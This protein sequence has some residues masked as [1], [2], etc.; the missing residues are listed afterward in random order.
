MPSV[1]AF[2]EN[3]L[4]EEREEVQQR[5]TETLHREKGALQRIKESEEA[6]Q[7]AQAR[8]A[9]LERELADLRAR[10]AY[11]REA[12]SRTVSNGVAPHE[13]TRLRAELIEAREIIRAMEEAYL[14]GEGFARGGPPE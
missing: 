1:G 5:E 13:L 3:R 9:E 6:R 4:Q 7:A 14:A 11:E 10:M 8:V 2:T 12:A